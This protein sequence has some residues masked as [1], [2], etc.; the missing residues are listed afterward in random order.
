[1]FCLFALHCWMCGLW[2]EH[3][4][5]NY[6]EVQTEEELVFGG[7]ERRWHKSIASCWLNWKSTRWYQPAQS[8]GNLTI[9]VCACRCG[10]TFL[11]ESDARTWT[12]TSVESQ[13]GQISEWNH[14]LWNG[15]TLRS[16]VWMRNLYLILRCFLGKNL[17]ISN[18][19]DCK[20]FNSIQLGENTAALESG[21]N[22]GSM[23]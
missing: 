7:S 1:M 23:S 4:P 14:M 5:N 2:P 13:Q 16:V 18:L 8:S 17:A 12:R 22:L 20:P 3:V 11:P 10:T 6:D 9:R 15:R 19:R 21:F